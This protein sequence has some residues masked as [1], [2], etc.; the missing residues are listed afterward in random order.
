MRDHN[1]NKETCMS[2]LRA[3]LYNYEEKEKDPFKKL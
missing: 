3:R 2:M 1:I